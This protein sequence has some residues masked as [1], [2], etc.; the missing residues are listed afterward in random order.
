[1]NKKTM[2]RRAFG[3]LALSV[4]IFVSVMVG[5]RFSAR[6]TIP[7]MG[8][9]P[10]LDVLLYILVRAIPFMLGLW[11][12]YKLFRPYGTRLFPAPKTGDNLLFDGV[13]SIDNRTKIKIVLLTLLSGFLVGFGF[14]GVLLLLTRLL[15][16]M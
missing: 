4:L 7:S 8:L 6:L 2:F 10:D 16:R 5:Y 11:L 14:F 1:M 15:L 9:T 13:I 3:G 12:L